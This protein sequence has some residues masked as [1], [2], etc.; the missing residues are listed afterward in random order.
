M[1]NH[2]A[3]DDLKRRAEAARR[4]RERRKIDPL[5]KHVLPTKAVEH[6]RAAG[7]GMVPC[8]LC[9]RMLK[10]SAVPRIMPDGSLL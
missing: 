8:A 6:V 7:G 5:C 4:S 3:L 1:S 9:G 2:R 10:V